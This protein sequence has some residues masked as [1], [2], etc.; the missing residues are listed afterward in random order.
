LTDR[1]RV[2]GWFSPGLASRPAVTESMRLYPAVPR[3][4]KILDADIEIAG[5][6]F[7]A[8]DIVV[9]SLVAGGRDP[10]SF[11]QPDRFDLHRPEPWYDIGFGHGGHYCLGIALAKAEMNAAL[12]VLTRRLTDVEF[13]G[14]IQI[15]AAGVICG[16]DSMPLRFRTR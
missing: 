15:K 9:L 11:A 7:Q 2:G 16:P 10:S 3:Q 4:V 12:T 13:D 5:R 1:G 6:L 8:G 14:E